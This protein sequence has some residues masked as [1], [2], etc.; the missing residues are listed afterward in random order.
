VE[1]TSA[2]RLILASPDDP[3]LTDWRGE[4]Y[5]IVGVVPLERYTR[6]GY[7]CML[8][9]KLLGL[10]LGREHGA[11]PCPRASFKQADPLLG[12]ARA[13]C[14]LRTTCRR[15]LQRNACR[16][17]NHLASR[18]LPAAARAL[19]FCKFQ[20]TTGH[21]VNQRRAMPVAGTALGAHRAQADADLRS[22]PPAAP[23]LVRRPGVAPLSL[24]RLSSLVRCVPRSAGQSV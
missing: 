6:G 17:D 3:I 10:V 19:R 5:Q 2:A 7:L 14:N 13:E 18:G 20:A 24:G 22:A 11:C 23:P 4:H 1:R 15:G 8:L 21:D 12:H 9:G 16:P